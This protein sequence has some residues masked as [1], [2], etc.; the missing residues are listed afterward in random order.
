L[1]SCRHVE[2]LA[3]SAVRG[4]GGEAVPRKGIPLRAFENK[5]VS[6]YYGDPRFGRDRPDSEPPATIKV[7][8]YGPD[9]LPLKT[10]EVPDE[11]DGD[12]V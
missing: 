7:T 8:I 2:T 5:S 10:I 3:R 1:S 12:P 9:G 4:N 6:S 11:D